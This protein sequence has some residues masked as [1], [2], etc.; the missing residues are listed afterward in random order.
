VLLPYVHVLVPQQASS[1]RNRARDFSTKL[2]KLKQYIKRRLGPEGL[3]PGGGAGGGAAAGGA[4][5]ALMQATPAMQ[6]QELSGHLHQVTLLQ[7][8]CSTQYTCLRRECKLP[9]CSTGACCAVLQW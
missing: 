5:G 4:A 9:I 2:R 3:P 6:Q 1:S 7:M 8:H